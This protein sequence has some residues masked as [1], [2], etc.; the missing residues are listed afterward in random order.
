VWDEIIIV[1]ERHGDRAFWRALEGWYAWASR[2]K[3]WS[4]ARDSGQMV[5]TSLAGNESAGA[6]IIE[7]VSIGSFAQTHEFIIESSDLTK[8]ERHYVTEAGTPTSDAINIASPGLRYAYSAGDTLRH[9]DYWPKL[10]LVD[11]DRPFSE[12]DFSTYGLR[13][14]AREDRA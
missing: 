13:I 14:R 10:I 9:A 2:G 1:L 7:V 4:F 12:D 8:R 3:Q 6:T 11:M 5:N